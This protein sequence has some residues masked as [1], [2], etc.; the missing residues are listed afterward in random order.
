MPRPRLHRNVIALGLVSLF[1]DFSSDMIYP[2]LP[3]FLT[4][5]LGA[6]PAA[7]GIIEGVAE[8]T[9]SILKLFSGAWSD[10]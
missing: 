3:V 6:G 4:A 2:L 1:T 10:R 9:A 5:T 8:A 7:L